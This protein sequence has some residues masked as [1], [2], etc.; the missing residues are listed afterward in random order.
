MLF[1]TFSIT[2][3][4]Q[5][6]PLRLIQLEWFVLSIVLKVISI[7]TL[8]SNK[9]AIRLLHLHVLYVLLWNNLPL[10]LTLNVQFDL[11]QI[12]DI[13]TKNDCAKYYLAAK[14]MKRNKYA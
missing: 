1:L 7:H 13:M 3:E 2:L 8:K 12:D 14:R 4:W 5:K 9:N 11:V 10:H 6:V